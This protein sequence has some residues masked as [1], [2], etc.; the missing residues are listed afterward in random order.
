MTPKHLAA[1]RARGRCAVAIAGLVI[2]NMLLSGCERDWTIPPKKYRYRCGGHVTLYG[3]ATAPMPPTTAV[4]KNHGDPAA[5]GWI[6]YSYKSGSKVRFYIDRDYL[7]TSDNP[8]LKGAFLLQLAVTDRTVTAQADPGDYFLRLDLA[9][10]SV[11]RLW[12]AFDTRAATVPTW[13][14]TSFKR[15]QPDRFI[16]SSQSYPLSG[17]RSPSGTPTTTVRYQL[18]EPKT[19]D[20]TTLVAK[21]IYLGGTAGPGAVWLDNT[22]GAQYLVMVRVRPTPDPSTK[23]RMLGSQ[24]VEVE[25]SA[26]SELS[27]SPQILEQ[28]KDEAMQAWL[29]KD[30]NKQ[31]AQAY[32]D[33]LIDI[34]V[35]PS[36]CNERCQTLSDGSVVCKE[37][38]E[39]S[40]GPAVV[41]S[42]FLSSRANIDV[43]KSW[44]KVEVSGYPAK[45]TPLR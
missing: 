6:T 43:S 15:V 23:L 44:A 11:D 20:I 12:I 40:S 24:R 25:A 10:R 16:E 35:D 4:T 14:A 19:T 17:H 8:M 5:K 41:N 34:D 18:W 9:G 39:L 1:N 32:S 22:V 45:T 29:A 31:Y 28:G 3:A 21:D 33:G 38:P 7:P 42:W 37:A 2:S 36:K 26:K 30:A 13:L 27:S